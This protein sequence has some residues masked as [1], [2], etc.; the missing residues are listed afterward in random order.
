MYV[1]TVRN[2]DQVLDLEQTID[3]YQVKNQ[4]T[5]SH[6]ASDHQQEEIKGLEDTLNTTRIA[7]TLQ[8]IQM[9]SQSIQLIDIIQ[10]YNRG[11]WLI[12]SGTAEDFQLVVSVFNLHPFLGRC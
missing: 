2:H 3:L 6:P 1:R 9:D 4:P 5:A 11:E 8:T 12:W 7:S 10:K